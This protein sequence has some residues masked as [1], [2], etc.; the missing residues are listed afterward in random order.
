MSSQGTHT[1]Q[2]LRPGFLSCR[3]QHLLVN[4]PLE[5]VASDHNFSQ[6][7]HCASLVTSNVVSAHTSTPRNPVVNC[8]QH[9]LYEYH[10]LAMH[11]ACMVIKYGDQVST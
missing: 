8:Y 7:K 2:L 11:E 10:V 6:I 9:T 4:S 1:A 5:C 3:G